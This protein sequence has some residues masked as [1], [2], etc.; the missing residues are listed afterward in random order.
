MIRLFSERPNPLTLQLSNFIQ[1]NQFPVVINEFKTSSEVWESLMLHL[2]STPH[3]PII[4][5]MSSC[6]TGAN[7]QMK[8]L[9]ESRI[10]PEAVE[11]CVIAAKR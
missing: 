11:I 6:N 4:D 5:L 2:K 10:V 7:G 8:E 3:Y 9:G 1:S